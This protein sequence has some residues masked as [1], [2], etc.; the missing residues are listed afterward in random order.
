MGD[1]DADRD[2]E[3]R[4][5]EA[6]GRGDRA[7]MESLLAAVYDQVYAVCR[8]VCGNDADADDA[9]QDALLAI[10]RSIGRFDGRS[11][12]RT[13][14]YRIA[15]NASL[16]E[17]RRRGRRP[18]PAEEERLQTGDHHDDVHRPDMG[19]TIADRLDIDAALLRLAPEFRVAVVL[20]DVIGMEYAD[21]A[22]AEGIPIGTVR[23][24]IARGR[25]QLADLV[26]PGNRSAAG[27]VQGDG[28]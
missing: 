6:A 28:P 13:W 11:A 12:V 1:T 27:D 26:D 24:R 22:E 8:R 19:T 25:R 17:L 4:W 10:V 3:R 23:S 15:T 14:V 2:Q 18:T 7:A 9:T 21:I 5:A 16:D 20:R